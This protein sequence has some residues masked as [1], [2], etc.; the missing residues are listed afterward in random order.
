M[1]LPRTFFKV[2][3]ANV[4]IAELRAQVLDLEKNSKAPA[5]SAGTGETLFQIGLANNEIAR[6]EQVIAHASASAAER[7]STHNRIPGGDA[8]EGSYFHSTPTPM[9][10]Q[11][12]AETAAGQTGQTGPTAD[13]VTQAKDLWKDYFAISDASDRARFF[14]ENEAALAKA[15]E[16]LKEAKAVELSNAWS[17]PFL[18]EPK[19]SE[20]AAEAREKREQHPWA[21]QFH[22]R[23]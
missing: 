6:L 1:S 3:Q 20:A 7:A 2:Q 11:A 15:S 9:G 21:R 13:Q 14:T 16:V 8:R 18:S 4:R 10:S 17:R 22:K 19:L 23:G 12:K 5:G